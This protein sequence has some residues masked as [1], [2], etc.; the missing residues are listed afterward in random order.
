M[1]FLADSNVDGAI[2]H[3]LASLGHEVLWAAVLPPRTPDSELLAQA[4]REQRLLITCDRDFGDLVFHRGL[5]SAGIV[6]MRFR[7]RFQAS[8]LA[9]LQG[10]WAD[11][12]PRM[13]GQFNV[14][15]NHR[16]RSRPLR[17]PS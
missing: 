2:V 1:K 13:A 5:I 8:R 6:L 16:I 17:N 3:W 12:E 11:L 9:L 10:F 15:T 7:T 4:N 14:L